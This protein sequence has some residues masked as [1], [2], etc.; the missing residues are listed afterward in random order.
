MKFLV[1][2]QLPRRMCAWLAS[3]GH[4]AL[5]TLDLPLGNRTSDAAV[6][7]RADADGRV[8]VRTHQGNEPLD[9][10][11]IKHLAAT[12]ASGDFEMESVAGATRADLDDE[13][14]QDFIQRRAAHLGRD[15]GQS[16]D[17]ILIAIPSLPEL[18]RRRLME[19]CEETG[20]RYR[21]MQSLGKTVL[22]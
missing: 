19:F 6:M 2:A 9:G 10:G 13:V 22:G 16:V 18:E 20:T 1:D 3:C 14:I 11:K 4:D 21:V 17:E 8:L 7:E 5:H 15:L 12:K